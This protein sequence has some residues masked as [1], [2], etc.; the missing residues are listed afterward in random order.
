MMSLM[1]K[2]KDEEETV[3]QLP[4][5]Y[6]KVSTET[7]YHYWSFLFWSLNFLFLGSDGEEDRRDQRGRDRGRRSSDR[8]EDQD[9]YS[10][11]EEEDEEDIG[12]FIV[13]AEGQPIHGKKKK[14]KA[15]YTDA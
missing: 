7:G 5:S 14:R 12:D 3:M 10:E 15:I 9:K 13:D 1:M 8:E 11:E 6:S 2:P 4:T